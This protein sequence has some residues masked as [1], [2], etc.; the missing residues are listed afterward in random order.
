ML[1]NPWIL[2]LVNATAFVLILFFG[3]RMPKRG[4]EIGILAMAATT[5]MSILAAVEWHKS[6]R[7]AEVREHTWFDFGS[8][9][10]QAGTI[11]DGL[12]VMMLFVV[13]FIS[14]LVQ[15]YSTNYMK[16]DRR[17]THFFAIMTFFTAS[18]QWFVMSSS[19]LQ[20][21]FGWEV[22]ALCSFLL[23]GHWWE[24]K[25]NVH[26]AMKAF[27]TTRA[28]D[29]GLFVG[30]S[31]LFFAAS[32]TFS[33]DDINRAAVSGSIS[34]GILLAAAIALFIAVVGKS[35]QFPLHTWLPDAMA[36][37]TPMS[38]LIHAATM[39]VA[40]VFLIARLFPVF[41]TAFDI[42]PFTGDLIGWIAFDPSTG[43][44]A[45][46]PS[47]SVNPIAVIGAITIV[48]AALLAFVQNDIKKVLSYSTVSQLGFMVMALGVG[49]WTAAM[50]HLFT[51]A[52]FKALL[53]LSAGSVSHTVHGF[54]IEK[55]MGGLRKSMPITHATFAIGAASLVG[56][57]PLA[58]FW[59]KEQ[60][61]AEA[62]A[63]GFM[64]FQIVGLVG[65]FL[66]AAYMMRCYYLMFWGEHRGSSK[67]HESPAAFTVP[68]IVLAIC[69]AFAGFLQA[70]ALGIDW[71]AEWIRPP[72]VAPH[73]DEASILVPFLVEMGFTVAGLALAGVAL[74]FGV[75]PRS[76][77]RRFTS[78]R[79][80]YH[81]LHNRYYL[82]WLYEKLFV[83]GIRR[84]L[85]WVVH[86]VDHNVVDRFVD[87]VGSSTV[88]V[89]RATDRHVDKRIID[90]AVHDATAVTEGAG[91]MLSAVQNGRVQRYGAVMMSGV[92]VL[93]VIVVV[94]R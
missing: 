68:C 82:D 39:V 28:S 38:A 25:R 69:S 36:G 64:A 90:G 67:P 15:I 59:S 3:T 91:A 72:F 47:A 29:A 30:V 94:A 8:F 62:G 78:A 76:L 75:G 93:A 66:T 55:D 89:A 56:I 34:D 51:H 81:V 17:Y 48:I 10:I 61:V 60:I 5:A 58:G 80:V 54:D 44:V 24:E 46:P 73:D 85:A 37:P 71:F 7:V 20:M 23:I 88:A 1:A 77:A 2:P 31:I 32:G 12:T 52:F 41:G 86:W 87:F 45:N 18:M 11:S 74:L 33:I 42:S 84:V 63:N 83:Q 21:I 26:A 65:T 14:L 70:P 53:F 79:A 92:A 9:E 13:S 19:T 57:L 4:S 22:M 6:D 16:N 35:A 27:L 50:F 40:G 49:A 43:T